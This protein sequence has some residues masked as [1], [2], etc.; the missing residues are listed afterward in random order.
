MLD[1]DSEVKVRVLKHLRTLIGEL[2]SR[3]C[4]GLL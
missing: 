1:A 4:V 3:V 2:Y